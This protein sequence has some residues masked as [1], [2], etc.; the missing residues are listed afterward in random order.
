MLR[1]WQKALVALGVVVGGPTCLL[2]SAVFAVAVLEAAGAVD[3]P[4]PPPEDSP[5]EEPAGPR[6]PRP[7]AR[8]IRVIDGDTVV[9]QRL[10]KVRL[11]GVNAP[12]KRRCYDDAATRFTRERLEDQVVQYEIGEEPKDRYDRTLAYLSRDSEMHNL[13]LLSGGYARV[14]TIPPNDKYAERFKRAEREAAGADVGLW[15]RCDRAAI[16]ARRAAARRREAEAEARRAAR[17]EARRKRAAARA[18][19]RARENRA[20]GACGP[21]DVD[22]DG[23]GVCNEGG[24]GSGSSGGSSRRS[25]GGGS[26][27]FTCGPGDID[28][29]NDGRCNE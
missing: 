16:R 19:R 25:S 26:G 2:V 21:G 4:E 22:G 7:G 28:G 10:G 20:A 5:E 23:D 9:M 15:N 1:P 13:A 6:G 14:L 11:I 17:A 29:D 12:E 24:G 27:R 8:V 18:R 3:L